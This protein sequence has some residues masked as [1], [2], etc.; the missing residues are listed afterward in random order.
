MYTNR[1][2]ALIRPGFM[3]LRKGRFF[4][5]TATHGQYKFI[6]IDRFAAV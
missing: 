1:L 4:S 3:S 2:A 6:E 5:E